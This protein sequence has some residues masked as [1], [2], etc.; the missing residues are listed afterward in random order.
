MGET[1]AQSNRRIRQQALREQLAAQKHVE[2]VVDSI[3]KLQNL[4]DE[5][6]AVEVQRLRAAIDSRLKLVNKYLPDQKEVFNEHT[7]EDGE[8]IKVTQDIVFEPVTNGTD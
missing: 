1:R 3:D 6:D 7:G 8:P 5:L 2:K 4:D